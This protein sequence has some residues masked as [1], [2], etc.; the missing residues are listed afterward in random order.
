[1]SLAS[2]VKSGEGYWGQFRKA[3][4]SGRTGRIG[5]TTELILDADRRDHRQ[6]AMAASH[7][8]TA[9]RSRCPLPH[10]RR[11]ARTRTPMARN[12]KRHVGR[13]WMTPSIGGRDSIG[14]RYESDRKG[15]GA[16]CYGPFCRGEVAQ[17]S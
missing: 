7:R 15:R 10:R 1:M 12:P 8:T 16:S 2:R 5:T 17:A 14:G 13:G 3:R 9:G 4:M 6:L 11:V